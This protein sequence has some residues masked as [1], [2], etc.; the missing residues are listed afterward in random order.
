M[1]DGLCTSC[2]EGACSSCDEGMCGQCD[3]AGCYY[4]DEGACTLYDINSCETCDEETEG[5]FFCDDACSVCDECVT[6]DEFGG[7]D[8]Y[9]DPDG[10][11]SNT[12]WV[13]QADGSSNIYQSIDE[14]VRQPSSPG[15]DDYIEGGGVCEYR[16]TMSAASGAAT[17]VT[18][19][20]NSGADSPV[21]LPSYT[22]YV[23]ISINGSWQG[24]KTVHTGT[25]TTA[26]A[27][28]S[29][30]W[31]GSWSQAD[32]ATLIVKLRRRGPGYSRV[33]EFYSHLS[34]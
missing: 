32:L 6:C 21:G 17:G 4:C 23:D 3:Q 28:T 33:Y 31:N 30:L 34:D 2:D 25:G 5:C 26:Q 18:I 10:D 11:S 29:H 19:W 13:D 12:G 16:C 9:M 8:P 22:L 15:T 27:W 24:E 1:D 7:G 20:V 14:G